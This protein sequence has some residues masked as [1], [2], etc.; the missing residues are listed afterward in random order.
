MRSSLVTLAFAAAAL[1][2]AIPGRALAQ[3]TYSNTYGYESAAQGMLNGRAALG[4][5]AAAVVNSKAAMAKAV[6]DVA[7]SNV[8]ALENLE[9][10]RARAI[11]NSVKATAT[12]YEKRK[13]A[14]A[15]QGLSAGPRPSREDLIRYS[16]AG[17][18]TAQIDAQGNILWPELFLRAEFSEFRAQVDYAFSHRNTQPTDVGSDLEHA[19]RTAVIQMRRELRHLMSELSPP[20]YAAARRFLDSVVL[21]LQV[22]PRSEA[23]LKTVVA[24]APN[25]GKVVADK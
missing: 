21:E 5:A 24:P 4:N 8:K 13:L 2:V 22:G 6:G 25:G 15:Y 23:M 16:K 20:E 10:A 14:D 7:T 9:S 3:R 17:L 18:S 11:E 1:S 19:A 12:F